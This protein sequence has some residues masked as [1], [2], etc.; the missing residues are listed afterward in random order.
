MPAAGDGLLD[1]EKEALQNANRKQTAMSTESH[2]FKL[3][4]IE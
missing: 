4:D 2:A 3:V 1:S